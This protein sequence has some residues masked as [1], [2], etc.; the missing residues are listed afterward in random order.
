M[1]KDREKKLKITGIVIVM[2]NLSI[3]NYVM[4]IFIFIF[5]LNS[6]RA[7]ENTGYLFYKQ[8]ET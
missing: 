5:M 8:T 1:K 7:E 2:S 3:R 6:S 4:V